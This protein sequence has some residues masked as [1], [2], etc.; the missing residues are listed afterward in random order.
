MSKGGVGSIT[1]N[2]FLRVETAFLLIETSAYLA[3]LISLEDCILFLLLYLALTHFAVKDGEEIREESSGKAGE[4]M[5][6]RGG[7]FGNDRKYYRM[8]L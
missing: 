6:G 7:L 2:F 1:D 8:V 3:L 4:L 5:C